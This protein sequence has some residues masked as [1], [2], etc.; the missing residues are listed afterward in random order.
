M[1]QKYR[2]IQHNLGNVVGGIG[3]QVCE[4]VNCSDFSSKLC[5][6][7]LNFLMPKFFRLPK[8]LLSSDAGRTSE[9][10]VYEE[11]PFTS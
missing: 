7:N 1:P 2:K 4:S 5:R 8:I 11:A 6:K 9:H 3:A 10:T